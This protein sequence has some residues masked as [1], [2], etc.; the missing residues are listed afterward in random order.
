MV[1]NED[2][3]ILKSIG[4]RL[5]SPLSAEILTK[6]PFWIGSMRWINSLIW[7][8]F[9]WRNKSKFVAYKLKEG[10]AAWWDQLQVSLRR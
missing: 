10:A 7:L 8:M 6:N 4:G 5:T 2:T 3:Q 9:P 1:G